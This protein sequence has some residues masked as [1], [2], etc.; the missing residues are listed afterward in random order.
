M[1]YKRIDILVILENLVAYLLSI[2]LRY[3]PRKS[4]LW[5]FGASGGFR[6]NPKYFFYEVF[7][8]HPEITPIW[9]ASSKK[10]CDFLKSQGMNAFF[11]RSLKGL[12]YSLRAKVYIVD[13]TIADVNRFLC[14]G[15]YYVNLWH[16]SSVKRVRWQNTDFFVK[17]FNLKDASEMRT[18]FWFKMRNY[19]ALF[20]RPDLCIAPSTIQLKEFF[21][22]MMDIAEESCKVAVFPRSRLM[23]EGKETAKNFIKNHEP[24]ETQ[25][26]IEKL[27]PYCKSY[28]YMP[29]W[30]DDGRDFIEQAGIDWHR[31]NDTMKAAQSLFILKLH[32]FTRLNLDILS[33]YSNICIYPNNS[34]VYAVLPFIDCLITDYSS[35][36]TDFLMMNK[37]IILFIFDYQNYVGKSNWIEDYDKYY[38]GKR[39]YD[40]SQVI[41]TIESGEDCH[42]PQEQYDFLMDFFWDNNRQDIDIAEEIKKRIGFE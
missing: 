4:T 25:E 42:I 2:V 19:I 7:K 5:V 13:H 33:Q 20:S 9:I 40:F 21:A 34:D 17:T 31:L 15:A 30:R 28:I 32:P 26:F 38:L 8:N 24:S 14:G 18:S 29:T 23:I 11:W 1:T 27:Q 36:Y 16:G 10:D 22:P 3:F 39:A 12:F 41:Q 37:E 6:D 35:I